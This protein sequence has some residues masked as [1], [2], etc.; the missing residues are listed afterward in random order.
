M[1]TKD[2]SLVVFFVSRRQDENCKGVNSSLSVHF[3]NVFDSSMQST[4]I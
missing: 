4:D 1:N 3:P 2:L